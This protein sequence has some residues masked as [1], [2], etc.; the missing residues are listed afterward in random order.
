MRKFDGCNTVNGESHRRKVT[1]QDIVELSIPI[2]QRQLRKS[3]GT[4]LVPWLIGKTPMNF[5]GKANLAAKEIL[6][7]FEHPESLP[8]P[9]ANIFIHRGDDVPCRKWSLRNQL[10]VAL[11]GHLDARGFRQ[12]EAVGRNVKKGEKAF[13]ILAPVT[14][15]WKDEETGEEKIVVLGFKSIAVFGF[16]QTDGMPI[17]QSTETETWVESLPVLEVARKWGLEVSAVD[18]RGLPFLGRYQ[19]GKEIL[20]AS[21]NL[22]T[23]T[24]EL[25][26]ASDDRLGTL[27]EYGQHCAAKWWPNLERQ[28]FSVPWTTR[29]I[30]TLVECGDT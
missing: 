6:K 11:H 13:Y 9:L 14:K 26:H 21:K 12:W 20:L 29:R 1:R 30:R 28:F 7:A 17:K 15:S 24:H 2:G 5:Y 4:V 3:R 23:W 16:D 18:G 25:C 27:T 19:R 8:A 22:T 10:L